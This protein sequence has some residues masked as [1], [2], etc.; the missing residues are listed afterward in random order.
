VARSCADLGYLACE[1]LDYS[2]AHTWFTDALRAF[3]AIDHACG[4]I[5]V[6][7]GFAVIAAMTGQS[8]RALVLGGAAVALRNATHTAGRRREESLGRARARSRQG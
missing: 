8:D 1:R 7:E 6:I 5:H 2:S 4:I 3:R